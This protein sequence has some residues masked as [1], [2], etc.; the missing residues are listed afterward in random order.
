M[1]MIDRR[2]VLAGA[3]ATLGGGLAAG[4][5]RARSRTPDAAATAAPDAPAGQPGTETPMRAPLINFLGGFSNPNLEVEAQLDP[6]SA[7]AKLP[8]LPQAK[9]DARALADVRKA[10]LTAV[11]LTLGYVSGPMDPFEFTVRDI[12]RWDR[13][14]REHRQALRKVYTAADITAAQAQGQLGVIYGFQNAVQLGGDLDR[15]D[16]FADL[17]VR[18]IQLTYNP[19]NP[20]GAGSMA[21]K[22]GAANTG[23]T[24]FGRQAVERLQAARVMVDLSHSGEKTCLDALAVAKGPIT[25]SHTGCRAL[26]DLPRNKTD[27]ELRGVAQGGGVVG[28]YFM[29]FLVPDGHA[30]ADDVVRHI[31]HALDVCGEDHV[32]IGTDGEVTGIDDLDRYRAVLRK[33]IQARRAAGISA[34]G[35]GEDTYP[36]VVDLRGP[37]QFARLADLLAKR[38]H[39]AARIDKILGGNVLRFA[40]DVW[41]A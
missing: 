26:C 35:E 10:G 27:A 6:Q 12:G 8:D 4:P 22:A 11:N 41:G 14:I 16:L 36:F 25:I 3:A 13:L 37:G 28:I 21:D 17:G 15:V 34:T 19:A 9:V 31:E 33:E 1:M 38:G 24:D 7:A 29:P 23:L 5:V 2:A 32:A 30:K 18:I 20:L 39:K 40:R